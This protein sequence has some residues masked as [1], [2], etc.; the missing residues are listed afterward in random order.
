MA[1]LLCRAMSRSM[2]C[3]T[4]FL[5]KYPDTSE[6]RYTCGTTPASIHSEMDRVVHHSGR[7][8]TT[9]TRKRA[10]KPAPSTRRAMA[11]GALIN[12]AKRHAHSC[13]VTS[14][15]TAMS[16]APEAPMAEPEHDTCEL[17]SL[18]MVYVTLAANTQYTT[19]YV[20]W[21]TLRRRV[22]AE[23]RWM[24]HARPSSSVSTN[25]CTRVML[26]PDKP[27]SPQHTR[28]ATAHSCVVDSATTCRSMSS[29]GLV[30]LGPWEP[31]MSPP[32]PTPAAAAAA[33]DGS[34]ALAWLILR[35][36]SNTRLAASSR[37]ASEE[38]STALGE[39]SKRAS[40]PRMRLSKGTRNLPVTASARGP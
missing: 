12:P 20:A 28:M 31:T 22:A 19:P 14:C 23:A 30:Y 33:A 24:Y 6:G 13:R 5:R 36:S 39:P 7:H 34:T 38:A 15:S 37:T 4:V 25:R 9:T 1:L 29:S 32:P 8:T 16:E 18:T 11:G 27:T 17:P 21:I 2:K 35:A 10:R 3:S 40:M 26:R